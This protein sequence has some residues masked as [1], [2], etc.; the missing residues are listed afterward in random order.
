MK[1]GQ[2]HCDQK[3]F[4]AADTRPRPKERN[5]EL[6]PDSAIDFKRNRADWGYKAPASRRGVVLEP[7]ERASQWEKETAL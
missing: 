7:D 6:G 2:S 3:D 1:G 4:L 5:E